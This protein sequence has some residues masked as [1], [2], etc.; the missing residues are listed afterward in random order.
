[1]APGEIAKH[2]IHLLMTSVKDYFI[3]VHFIRT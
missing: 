3:L 1:M 2:Q